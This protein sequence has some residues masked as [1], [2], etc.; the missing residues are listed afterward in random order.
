MQFLELRHMQYPIDRRMTRVFETENAKQLTKIALF[1]GKI[2][3]AFFN[4]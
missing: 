2:M 4:F 1:I 3:E